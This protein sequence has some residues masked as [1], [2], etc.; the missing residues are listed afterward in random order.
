VTGGWGEGIGGHD[1]LPVPT[2]EMEI[3]HVVARVLAP[4]GL[5]FDRAMVLP[6]MYREAEAALERAG[7][8]SSVQA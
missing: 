2:L 6:G 5:P 8:A 4:G 3:V 7:G 1:G